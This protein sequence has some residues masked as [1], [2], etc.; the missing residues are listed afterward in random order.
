[1]QLL[2]EALLRVLGEVNRMLARLSADRGQTLAE[3]SL[4]M[5]V[6][7]VATVVLALTVFRNA[8]V[9]VF[10]PVAQCINGNGNCR[11]P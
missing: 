8:I 7:A 3:Y 4:I 1:M 6:V 10:A 5:T 2:D 9:N 11:F